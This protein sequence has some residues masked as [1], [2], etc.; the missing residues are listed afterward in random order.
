MIPE[1]TTMAGVT[2]HPPIPT[3]AGAVAVLWDLPDHQG[4]YKLLETLE[5]VPIST[6]QRKMLV[7]VQS[8]GAQTRERGSALV[9]PGFQP[10]PA[11]RLLLKDPEAPISSL[12]ITQVTQQNLQT[13]LSLRNGELTK[14]RQ[15]DKR[16]SSQSFRMRLTLCN[17]V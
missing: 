4:L 17:R 15:R 6:S 1:V 3:K 16:K 12:L 2:V 10:L 8:I 9:S 7:G 13:R 5:I 11:D 14:N